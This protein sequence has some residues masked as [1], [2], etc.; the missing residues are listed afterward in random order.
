MEDAETIKQ[1][2]MVAIN[3]CDD[4]DLLDL[5]YKLLAYETHNGG[6]STPPFF[7]YV[8][9]ALQVTGPHLPSASSLFFVWN[10]LTAF[11]VA[12]P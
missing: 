6:E 3:E 9:I 2:I 1:M 5:V 12:G 4:I 7:C 11:S 8:S 10:S